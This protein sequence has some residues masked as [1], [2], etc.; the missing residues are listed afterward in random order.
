MPKNVGSEF[1]HL[2]PLEEV[3][4]Q[5]WLVQSGIQDLGKPDSHYDYRGY[6]KKNGPTPYTWGQDHLPDTFKQHGHHTFS[7]ESQYSQGPHDGGIWIGQDADGND[8]FLPQPPLAIS[9]K[10]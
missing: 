7:Q 10:K 9:H 5:R 8:V 6:F 2:S 4:F 3:L 1:T